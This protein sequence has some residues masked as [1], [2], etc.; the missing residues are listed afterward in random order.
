MARRTVRHP[1]SWR[2]LLP[3]H[4]RASLPSAE[5]DAGVCFAILL[6]KV[7]L[8]N[9]GSL[10]YRLNIS[11]TPVTNAG[12]TGR[13]FAPHASAIAE[14]ASS[15]SCSHDIPQY[16][17]TDLNRYAPICPALVRPP[18]HLIENPF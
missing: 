8:S 15:R 12:T 1:Y 17:R 14:R 4:F 16:F 3:S 11:A 2:V 9:A 6:T 13:L 10:R 18:P 7:S 5:I